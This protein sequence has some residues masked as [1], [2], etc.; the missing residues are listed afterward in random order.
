MGGTL[1]GSSLFGTP[2]HGF[3]RLYVSKVPKTSCKDRSSALVQRTPILQTRRW[4]VQRSFWQRE[5]VLAERF[6]HL[7][8]I[9][10]QIICLQKWYGYDLCPRVA[11]EHS[12]PQVAHATRIIAGDLGPAA[13]EPL[14]L[15][16]RAALI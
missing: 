6:T 3:E 16:S 10:Q 7:V 5:Q 8:E 1:P 9:H 15:R 11:G 13:C 14:F 12:K 2:V 4:P